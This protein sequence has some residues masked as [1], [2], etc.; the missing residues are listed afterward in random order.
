MNRV[1]GMYWAEDGRIVT[2]GRVK[3]AGIEALRKHFEVFPELYEKVEARE[4]FY[5]YLEVG[6]RVVIEHDILIRTRDGDHAVIAWE[7]GPSSGRRAHGR[8]HPSRSC[9]TRVGALPGAPAVNFR[10]RPRC[11]P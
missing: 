1:F 7:V 4:P 10:T 11:S 5:T 2:F 6:D 3:A 8:R 9:T